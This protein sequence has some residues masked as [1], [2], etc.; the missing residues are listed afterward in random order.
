MEEWAAVGRVAGKWV[1]EE[2]VAGESAAGEWVAGESVAE[3]WVAAE[4]DPAVA[5][6]TKA[7]KRMRIESIP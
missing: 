5:V 3:E 2:W 7:S 6:E 4:P 1:V